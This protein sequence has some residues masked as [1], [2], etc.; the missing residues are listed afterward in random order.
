MDVDHGRADAARGSRRTGS[1]CSGPARRGRSGRASSSSWRASASGLVSLVTGMCSKRHAE[2]RDVV[3]EV[4]VVGDRP[5]RC[6]RRA[7]RGASATAGRA[8]SG[9]RARPA[10]P[11]AWAARVVQAQAIAKR[12]AISLVEAASH[13]V[14]RPR[15]PRRW[16]TMRRKNV[17]LLGVG[18]VLVGLVDVGALR[19][20]EAGHRGDDPG[21]V[22]APDEQAAGVRRL[23]RSPSICSLGQICLRWPASRDRTVSYVLTCPNCGPREVTD[24]SFGGEVNPVRATTPSPRELGA[25][26]YFR[27]NVAGRAAR[28][29]VP[30]LRLRRVV[31]RRARHAH[32]PGAADGAARLT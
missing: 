1:A 32:Q 4:R 19:V 3:G 9:P 25:Y 12:W 20:Q 14:E 26:N 2:L 15:R 7:R 21:P 10:A 29:V 17:P 16:N 11:P 18:R 8:G 30:P 22:L 24:F 28:V 27:D 31:P 6:R 23:V 5:C 13:L